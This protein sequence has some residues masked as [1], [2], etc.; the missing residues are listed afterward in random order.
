MKYEELVV[1]G[2][3][4]MFAYAQGCGAQDLAERLGI[5]VGASLAVSGSANNR[6]IRSTIKHSYATTRPT[7]YVL[8]MTMLSREELPILQAPN[9]LE[10]AWTNPQNQDFADR[11]VDI[12]TQ[13]ETERYVEL[14][15]KWEV[16]SIKDRLED[17]QYRILSMINDLKS[18]GHNVLVFQQ[19]DSIYQRYLN[20]EIFLPFKNCPNIVD[21]FA[22]RATAW[23][24]H[25][26]V[27]GIDYSSGRVPADMAHP[28]P[29]HHQKLNEFLTEY[30]KEHKIIE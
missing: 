1:N 16:Y 27:P 11:W 30:I 8:G 3:S 14:K 25:N 15:L 19:A 24:H 4:Y 22:W 9:K 23:Q 5:P 10:G 12:W 20:D 29:G 2:C 28:V 18:R 6:I 26:G 13:K 17:L 21:G 7:F